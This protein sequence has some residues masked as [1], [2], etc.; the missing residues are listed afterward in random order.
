VLKPG[1]RSIGFRRR[2]RVVAPHFVNKPIAE[3]YTPLV[4]QL[5]LSQQGSS[6]RPIS[7]DDL[8]VGIAITTLDGTLINANRSLCQ[9]VGYSNEE[10]QGQAFDEVFQP[11][12]PHG[13][14]EDRKLLLHHQSDSYFAE[15]S[16]N[17]KDGHSF[18]VRIA[19]SLD[20]ESENATAPELI[21]VVQDLTEI[22]SARAAL[23]EEGASRRELAQR[24]TTALESER[25]RIAREL[26]DDIG[27]ELAILRIQFLRAGQPVSG[28][29]GKRHA[30]VAELCDRLRSVAGK[31]SRLSH[32]LHSS[33]LEY[34]GLA[35]AVQSHCREF[36]EKH[37]IAVE[38]S[39]SQMPED[40]DD[41]HALSLLR[42][43]QEALHNVAKH[44][45]AKSAKVTL[46]SSPEE[47]SLVI[48]DDGEG[49]DLE[50]AR[51]SAG[52]GL[53]SMRERTNLAGGRFVI[54]SQAGQGTRISAT[55]PLR[56]ESPTAG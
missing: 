49:F 22:A 41:L 7:L 5:P 36:S 51:L 45:K 30:T 1:R 44:S 54:S 18:P 2:V 16:A 19:F 47:I 10:L 55:V 21:A 39:C 23:R 53:I 33:E 8:A 32:Q 28:M 42:V 56:N 50:E 17:H 43:V 15:R 38:C 9:M 31:V 12:S 37:K 11:A 46:T 14:P 52:L 26:H 40:L 27:Q 24:L 34:L 6:I 4:R 20:T 48:T 29:P 25:S 13:E 3:R 35:V